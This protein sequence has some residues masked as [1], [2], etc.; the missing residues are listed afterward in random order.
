VPRYFFNVAYADSEPDTEGFV[1][2]DIYAAQKAAV[3]MS[4]EMIK[5]IDGRFWDAP[6]WGLEIRDHQ[7][8]LMVTL[9]FSGQTH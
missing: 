1:F 8:T 5:E 7:H 6:K 9:M 3:R 4:G 2:D